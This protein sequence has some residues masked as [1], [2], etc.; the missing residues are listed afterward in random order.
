MKRKAAGYVMAGLMIAAVALSGCSDGTKV[1]APTSASPSSA[2]SGEG[3]A[4]PDRLE[5][6]TLIWHY[7]Q[8]KAQPDLQLVEDAVNEITQTKINA[9]IKLQPF[10]GGEYE[11]KMN[12][13]VSA[14]DNFDIAFTANWMFNYSNN[15]NKGA[16]VPL[17][18]LIERHGPH[19]KTMMPEWMWE[20]TKV[21]GQIYGVPTYQI[22]A[23]SVGILLQKRFVDKYKLDL[24]T[25]RKYEDL[26]PFFAQLKE[27]EPDIVPWG[28]RNFFSGSLYGFDDD[29]A[30]KVRVGD[31]SNTIV[32]YA[33]TPEYEAYLRLA[34][35]WYEKGYIHPDIAT[36]KN[37]EEELL[38]K[39]LV[40]AALDPTSKPG[41]EVE[42]R[43]KWG[44]NELVSVRLTEPTFTGVTSGLNAISRTSKN[45]ERALMFLDLVNSDSELYNLLSYGIEGKHYA[46][47]G[48]NAIR[49]DA[50]SGYAPNVPWVMGSVFNGYLLEG[51]A[52]DTWERTKQMNESAKVSSYF[53]FTFNEE[54]VLTEIASNDAVWDKYG[55]GLESG[56]LDPDKYLPELRDKLKQAGSEK[57]L[58]EKQNQLNEWLKSRQ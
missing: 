29:T 38:N 58:L 18:E 24:G 1:N 47:T 48:P 50:S 42:E 21:Q 30:A 53:G 14:G 56:T 9:T 52:P 32:D 39:G 13:I 34:R 28:T 16:F 3:G 40:A 23:K 22:A 8:P 46:V 45:P 6:V 43:A 12:T 7:F 33:F 36:M 57:L 26:E 41:G 54:P 35:S 2:A 25:I 4:A 5:P 49:I 37:P 27:N 55:A 15:A 31:S 51:Q 11:D 10:D 17:D 19:L 44:N 20:D